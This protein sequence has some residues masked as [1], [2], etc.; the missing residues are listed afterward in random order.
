MGVAQLYE[1][2][3]IKTEISE[4]LKNS[5]SKS[6]ETGVFYGVSDHGQARSGDNK[7]LYYAFIQRIQI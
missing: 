5:S 1:L 3:P 4:V 6:R 7:P 2:L